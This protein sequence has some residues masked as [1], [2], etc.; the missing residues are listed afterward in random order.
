[1]SHF[2]PEALGSYQYVFKISDEHTRLTEIYLLKSKDGA[3]HAF[4]SF[5]QSMVI[6]SGVYVERLKGNKGGEFIGN[7]AKN[8]CT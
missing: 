2:T 5:V 4:Q 1:M 8:Y 7:D 3:L 6:P